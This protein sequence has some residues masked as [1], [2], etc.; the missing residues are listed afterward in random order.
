MDVG[1]V[2]ATGAALFTVALW[3]LGRSPAL[4]APG[5]AVSQ[6]SSL[7]AGA[8]AGTLLRQGRQ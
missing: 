6:L 3:G 8:K 4:A 5:V 1:R 2:R 7:K